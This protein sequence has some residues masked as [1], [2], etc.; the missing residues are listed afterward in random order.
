MES[1]HRVGILKVMM[2]ITMNDNSVVTLTQLKAYTT[3][4]DM[5]VFHGTGRQEK[6]A[7]IETLLSRFFYFSLRKRDKVTIRNYI[8]TMTGYSDAQVTRLIRLK[9]QYRHI[10]VRAS[11]TRSTFPTIYT[12]A[13]I[14]CLLETDNAHGRLSGPATQQLFVRAYSLFGDERFVR[15]KDISVSHLYNL[16]GKR[17][18]RSQAMTWTKTRPTVVP[19]GERRKPSPEGKPGFMRVDSVHQGDLDKAKGVYHIN[20]VDEVTQWELVGCVEGISEQ[21]LAPLLEALLEQFPF[22]VLAFHSDN[23]SEY[24][25]YVVAKLLNK[26]TLAQTKSRPRKSNDNA[27]V[28]GKNGAVIRK[29][30]GYAHIPRQHASAINTFYQTHFNTYVNFH[31]PSGYATTIVTAN[32]KEKKVYQLYETPYAHL[33][34]LPEAATSLK[35]GVT[36]KELDQLAQSMSDLE[37]AT[38]MQEAKYNL[39]KSFRR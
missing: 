1:I 33:K 18:Y 32:G 24:I 27:L 25:N 11:T 23:G 6:Y 22:Q 8:M 9:K 34:A 17:Q 30:M 19:I 15:L 4:A 14:A 3:A 39:F 10:V 13:D 5:I 7:W 31:R 21:F 36:F 38:L 28:E 2:T 26:L 12:P 16:R 29:H 37:C 20:L 35:P